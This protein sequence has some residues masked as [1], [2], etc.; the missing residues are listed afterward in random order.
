MRVSGDILA[1]DFLLNHAFS[2]K[3]GD[4]LKTV[5]ICLVSNEGSANAAEPGRESAGSTC[6]WFGGRIPC[7]GSVTGGYVPP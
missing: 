4:G 6:R 3:V 7:L 5:V 1:G 2:A